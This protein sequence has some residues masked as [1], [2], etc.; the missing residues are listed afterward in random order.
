MNDKKF[1]WLHLSD[2]HIGKDETAE[3]S[4]FKYIL[5][6]VEERIAQEAA[7]DIILI[8]GDIANKGK[9]AEYGRFWEEFL[10]PLH[11][12]IGNGIEERTFLVP[13]NHDLDRNKNKAFDRRELLKSTERY[14]DASKEGVESR[15]MLVDRFKAFIDS[16]LTGLGAQFQQSEGAYHKSLKIENC[17]ISVVGINTAWLCKD[18]TDEH[19]LN[20]GKPLLESAL[21]KTRGDDIT[22][23][24]GHHPISWM[25]HD[26]QR[27]IKALLAQHHCI[28]LHGHLHDAWS[29]P[30]AGSGDF[31]LAVQS[32]AAF[33][34]RE[35]DIWRNGLVWGEA[36]IGE[37]IV[38]LQPNHWNS[39]HQAWKINFDAFPD[40]DRDGEW[41]SYPLPSA[42]ITAGKKAAA[43]KAKGKLPGGWE[44]KRNSDLDA[45]LDVMEPETALAYFDGA[46]PTWQSALSRSTPRREVIRTLANSFK[47]PEAHLKPTITLL[48]AAGC[49]GKT[50]AVLQ[51]AYEIVKEDSSW[52][53]LRRTNDARPFNMNELIPFLHDNERWL[54]ILDEA[55]QVASAI[56]SFAQSGT[57]LSQGKVS[58]LLTCRETDW[59]SSNSDKVAWAN[60]SNF[61]HERLSGLTARD[62]E[63]I[64][65]AWSSYGDIGLGELSSTPETHRAEKLRDAAKKEARTSSGA[66]FGALLSVRHGSDLVAHAKSML[67]KLETISIP[68]GGTLKDAMAFISIMHSENLDYLSIP[69]LAKALSCD[70]AKFHATV[71]RPLGQEA[72]ATSTS[73]C[74]YTRHRS[75]ASAIVQVLEDEHFE[76]ISQLFIELCRAAI[77]AY[78][79]GAFVKS[80]ELWR[81]GLADHFHATNRPLLSI[82]IA[83]AVYDAEPSAQALTHLAYL[84]RK[85]GETNAPL[86]LYRNFGP[87]SGD[88]PYFHEWSV[89]EYEN[90]NYA[91][92]SALAGYALSD[93]CSTTRVTTDDA[94]GYLGGVAR[95]FDN[96]YNKYIE[97]DF[98]EASYAAYSLL[99]VFPAQ[100]NGANLKDYLKKVEKKR[101]TFYEID[102]ARS[103]IEKAIAKATQ[104][105]TNVATTNSIPAGGVLSL[106]GLAALT[107]NARNLGKTR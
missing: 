61:R 9:S 22:L 12:L 57:E 5:R 69:V 46:V 52:S 85:A 79:D 82:E 74:V 68:S 104:F 33:Q 16:D 58:F 91:D 29:E 67:D 3:R 53:I 54:I 103:V 15:Q 19:Q 32:G 45:H 98:R 106:A 87:V 38:R 24:I 21:D 90:G 42:M 17:N 50:T 66:F 41:W 10:H 27:P 26:Q 23:V 34:A 78:Q 100:A 63:M 93:D 44:I 18:S 37:G 86:Q 89:A 88:R 81:F 101:A 60:F 107:H 71:I 28:Y 30:N 84:Y 48:T 92:G 56:R 51:A 99:S 75:I 97:N 25:A 4:M 95:N 2:F 14:F 83:K 62:A 43:A 36:S 1:K 11:S 31:F 72:A 102:Q 94:K 49:E 40:Q 8:T 6:H 80:L 13:G 65:E 7:P 55:D 73:T 70:P 59:L 20:L 96:L 105:G 47:T 35:G 39:N 77:S 64:V 76:N